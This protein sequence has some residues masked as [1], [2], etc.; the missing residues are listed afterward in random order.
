MISGKLADAN[1][2]RIGKTDNFSN[3]HRT[4]TF[5]VEKARLQIVYPLMSLGI[6]A[7]IPYGWVLARR[8][9]LP[10]PLTLQFIIGFSFVG[11]VNILSTLIV[12]LFPDRPSTAAAACNIV[13]CWL[14]AVGAATIEQMLR[15]VGWGWG[16]CFLG[17]LMGCAFV[18]IWAEQERGIVWRERRLVNMSN[19]NRNSNTMNGMGWRR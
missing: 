7:F 18:L 8:S 11:T 17:I 3:R 16:F 19:G 10:V 13:R 14:G 2:K 4:T 12:D 15:G 9:P 1:Y 5:P 6:A